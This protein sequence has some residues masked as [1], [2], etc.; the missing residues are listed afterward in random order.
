MIGFSCDGLECLGL[1]ALAVAIMAL[2]AALVLS[3]SWTA[4]SLTSALIP[5]V[6]KPLQWLVVG[7]AAGVGAAIGVAVV[8]FWF[9]DPVGPRLVVPAAGALVHL[10]GRSQRLRLKGARIGP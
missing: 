6:P 8:S 9:E 1:V 4:G 10:A 3:A 2:G 7:V 5:R